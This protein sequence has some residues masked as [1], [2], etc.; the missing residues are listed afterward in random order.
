MTA[1]LAGRMPP[2]MHAHAHTRAHTHTHVVAKGCQLWGFL[3]EEIMR[4]HDLLEK[5]RLR[6][7]PRSPLSGR[8]SGLEIHPQL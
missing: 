6:M 1:R 8:S 3:I 4:Q 7:H 5:K 2:G